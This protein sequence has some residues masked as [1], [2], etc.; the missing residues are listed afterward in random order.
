MFFDE[1]INVRVLRFLVTYIINFIPHAWGIPRI[2]CQ[3]NA[4]IRG[5]HRVLKID[6]SRILNFSPAV[7]PHWATPR[8]IPHWAAPRCIPHWAAH[9]VSLIEQP[10]GVSLI[11]QSTVYPSLSSPAVYPSLSS[12]TVYPSLSSPAVYPSLSSP[13]VYSSLSSPTVYPSLSSPCGVSLIEQPHGVSLIIEHL[14]R[15][16]RFGIVKFL[17]KRLL[18][19]I[20][21]LDFKDLKLCPPHGISLKANI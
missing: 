14:S 11:E 15:L 10:R 12:P 8:W 2:D 18:Y 3:Q 4:D 6:V 13:T 16:S 20:I 21:Y 19:S 1:L 7:Y 5:R 17:L 9:G